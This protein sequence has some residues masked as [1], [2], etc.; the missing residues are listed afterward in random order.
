MIAKLQNLYFH[1]KFIFHLK[2]GNRIFSLINSR[3]ERLLLEELDQSNSDMNL[4]FED[5]NQSNSDTDLYFKGTNQ[6][7]SEQGKFSKKRIRMMDIT[8]II[9]GNLIFFKLPSNT[10]IGNLKNML[11]DKFEKIINENLRNIIRDNS[12][13]SNPKKKK[14]RN[15]GEKDLFYTYFGNFRF[16]KKKRNKNKKDP[17]LDFHTYYGNFIFNRKKIQVRKQDFSINGKS[18]ENHK[19]IGH[20]SQKNEIIISVFFNK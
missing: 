5:T 14:K 9:N 18:L 20:Y 11:F 4:S 13:V 15:K 12:P 1:S 16:N 10:I 7:N 3:S 8:L 19:T 2:N 6:S 17:F